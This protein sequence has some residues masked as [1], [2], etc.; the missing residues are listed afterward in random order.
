MKLLPLARLKGRIEARADFQ[1][2]ALKCKKTNYQCGD[3]CIPRT[4]KCRL[5]EKQLEKIVHRYED[6]IKDLPT[7][8]A[9]IIDD[10]GRVILAKNGDETS[11][12]FTYTEL[13]LM[14]NSIVTHNHPNLGWDKSDVRSQGLSFSPADVRLANIVESKEMRAV[15]HGYRHSLKPPPSGWNSTFYEYRVKPT[16]AKYEREVY[17]EFASKLIAKQMSPQA[18]ERDYHHEV[19]KRTAKDT[20]MIYKREE[21]KNG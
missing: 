13:L 18:A 20:G 16:Y 1:N 12:S 17:N 19:I 11:V 5:S 15:S 4:K 7:E 8:K 10:K 6:K 2:K 21:I 14:K 9:L 3:A